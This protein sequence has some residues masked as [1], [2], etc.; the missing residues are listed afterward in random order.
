MKTDGISS[1]LITLKTKI[2]AYMTLGAVGGAGIFQSS[3]ALEAAGVATAV[4]SLW[5]LSRECY[6]AFRR[7]SGKNAGQDGIEQEDSEKARLLRKQGEHHYD[8]GRKFQSGVGVNSDYSR[9]FQHFYEGAKLGNRECAAELGTFY[10]FGK[11]VPRNDFLAQYWYEEGA[12]GGSG[13]ACYYLAR[14]YFAQ[15]KK[16][17]EYRRRA[18]YFLDE[19]C[20]SGHAKALELRSIL[21]QKNSFTDSATEAQ[22]GSATRDSMYDYAI[23]PGL[24]KYIFRGGTS[25]PA[26]IRAACRI[27][28][29]PVGD[30]GSFPDLSPRRIRRHYHERVRKYHPDADGSCSEVDRE[31]LELLKR[32]CELLLKLNS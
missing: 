16:L 5:L 32:A 9:A 23:H 8:L 31:K 15:E 4:V 7:R 11:G 17:P 24:R 21:I 1:R 25:K 30:D 18:V 6:L 19:A 2:G 12:Y 28:G 20:F 27:L 14:W 22:I 13:M 3:E 10:E 26:E 29:F